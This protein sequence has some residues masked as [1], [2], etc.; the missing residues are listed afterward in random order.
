MRV[1][2]GNSKSTN[3]QLQNNSIIGGMLITISPVIKVENIRRSIY[4]LELY[5]L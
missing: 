1:I 2:T 3:G 5:Y 4:L